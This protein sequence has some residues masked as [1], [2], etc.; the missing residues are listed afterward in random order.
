MTSCRRL[1]VSAQALPSITR[2]I[3][4][5]RS[6]VKTKV[7]LVCCMCVTMMENLLSLQLLS[8]ALN[9]QR[10]TVSSNLLDVFMQF[11]LAGEYLIRRR[12]ASQSMPYSLE[13]DE[14]GVC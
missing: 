11:C 10:I 4:I 14:R 7:L 3:S 12:S 9:P 2:Y 1:A 13:M 8:D 6:T 5:L